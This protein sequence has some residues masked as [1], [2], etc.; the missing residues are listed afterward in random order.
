[1]IN[2]DF[3]SIGTAYE[4]ELCYIIKDSLHITGKMG[5]IK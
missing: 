4:F 1:M 2:S 5:A 3:C